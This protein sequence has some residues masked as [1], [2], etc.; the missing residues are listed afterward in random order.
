MAAKINDPIAPPKGRAR[1]PCSRRERRA[2]DYCKSFIIA[3]RLRIPT[4]PAMHSNM[5]PATY[6]EVKPAG[7]PI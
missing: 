2:A 1:P 3:E 5:K 7:I 4:K 6:S